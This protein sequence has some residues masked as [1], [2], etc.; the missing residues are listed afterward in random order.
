[1]GTRLGQTGVLA[2]VLLL[3]AAG[4]AAAHLGWR[5]GTPLQFACEKEALRIDRQGLIGCFDE[6]PLP[7]GVR[8]TLGLKLDLNEATADELML[9]S[10][11]GPAF[12][13]AL[14]EAR[15]AAKGFRD[16]DQVDRVAGVGMVR[17]QALK[18]STEIR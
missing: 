5:R 18:A 6:A 9:I 7:A 11:I 8:L 1:M 4:A 3:T 16:W 10:G 13:K 14:V 12:A 2:W 17:L 15:T